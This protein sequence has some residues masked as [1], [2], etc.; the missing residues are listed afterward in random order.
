MNINDHQL[1]L[2]LNI[3]KNK[4]SRNYTNNIYS[5]EKE[6]EK[7]KGIHSLVL[8]LVKI[9]SIETNIQWFN[10][11]YLSLRYSFI[12]NIDFIIK[13]PNLFYLDLYQNPIETFSPFLISNSFG[14]L[15][16][17]PPPNYF[18]QKILSI[19][20]LNIIFL[21]AD[22]KDPSI[23]K[24]FL[25]KNPN[26]M[27][28]N[29]EIL[30][31]EYKIQLYNGY[32]SQKNNDKDSQKNEE[33][34]DNFSFEKNSITSKVE[35]IYSNKFKVKS[36]EGCTNKKILSIENFI[37]EYNNKM[38]S[39]QKEGKININQLKINLEE[40]RK[41]I[42]ISECYLNLLELNN[43]NNEFYYKYIPIKEKIDSEIINSAFP[44]LK[45]YEINLTIFKKFT[46]PSLKEFLLSILI[47]YI[48][49]ILS[50]DISF[51][52]LKLILLKS[53][54][55]LENKE[56]K[57]NLEN[58]ILNILNLEPNILICLYYKIYDILFGIFSNKRLNDIQVKLQMNGITDKIMSLIQHQNEFIKLLKNNTDPLKQGGIIRNELILYLNQNN[59]FNNILMII[60]YVDDYI[61]YNNI[62]KKLAL[63]NSKDLQFFMNIKNYMYF[64]LDKRK[65]NV[66]SMAEK[67]FNKI[68][69]KSLFHN[70]YFFDTENYMKTNK[71]CMNVFLNYKHG[72]FYPDKNKIK[73]IKNNDIEEELKNK[74]KEKI[75][76]LY[77]QN[78]LNSFFNIIKEKKQIKL[79]KNMFTLRTKLI[80]QNNKQNKICG[81]EINIKTMS[82]LNNTNN[83]FHNNN[84]I[85]NINNNIRKID[86]I[87][88]E[89]IKKSQDKLF[90]TSSNFYS[91]SPPNKILYKGIDIYSYS[92]KKNLT[93]ETT[94]IYTNTN[95]IKNKK[96]L[97][98]SPINNTIGN[99]NINA[100]HNM[101]KLTFN[102]LSK[103]KYENDKLN[104]LKFNSMNE[105]LNNVDL[106]DKEFFLKLKNKYKQRANFKNLEKKLRQKQKHIQLSSVKKEN[107][108]NTDKSSNEFYYNKSLGCRINFKKIMLKENAK[109]NEELNSNNFSFFYGL[110]Q[111]SSNKNLKKRKTNY[112]PNNKDIII[113]INSNSENSIKARFYK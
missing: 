16:F 20:K 49:K 103:N 58:D 88:F 53:H 45:H 24:T 14:F 83:F 56:R 68:Q 10:L 22:I 29:N 91:L 5:E 43:P 34:K 96:D 42:T 27:V 102:N 48:F 98:Q 85:K 44:S 21:L 41:L 77:V 13:M 40:K 71:Y 81:N 2:L 73:K 31:F 95:T 87:D 105:V 107:K 7:E 94:T 70:K 39:Q 90:K 57:D 104:Y 38:L 26:I 80:N 76:N 9:Y 6:K 54:Y 52:L 97:I 32:Q 69:M 3:N 93:N 79:N 60:Q 64:S 75:K 89:L 84:Y 99:A 33:E 65:E 63:Q 67:K 110:R 12:K 23:K 51:E 59:I 112:S 28:L 74:K 113:N 108:Y 25:Q 18:E 47:L 36:K 62:Q 111:L 101:Y 8:D 61:I 50:K 92:N 1:K 15:C 11:E 37:K 86:N 4:H 72:I 46:I 78:N 17:S 66:Q 30:D 35:I 82:N 109:K 55:Y 106:S 19:E 100:N